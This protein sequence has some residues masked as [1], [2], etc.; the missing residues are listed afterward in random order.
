MANETIKQ[1]AKIKGVH[2]WEIANELGIADCTFSRKLR[3]ELDEEQTKRVL[4]IIEKL[5][6]K[7]GEKK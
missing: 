4:T 2:M 1:N 5:S 6:A 3:K 7:K